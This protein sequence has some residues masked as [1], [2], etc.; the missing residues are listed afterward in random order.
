MSEP[1]TGCHECE[2][3]GVVD[4][5]EFMVERVVDNQELFWFCKECDP[6][7]EDILKKPDCMAVAH[8]YR[9]DHA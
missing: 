8:A 5:A 7:E 1:M 2:E 6:G 4:F 3:C 9:E